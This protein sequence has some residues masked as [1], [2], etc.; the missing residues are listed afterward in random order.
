MKRLR[1]LRPGFNDTVNWTVRLGMWWFTNAREGE[2]IEIEGHDH[3][4]W[5]ER[6]KVTSLGHVPEMVLQHHHDPECRSYG[7]LLVAMVKAYPDKLFW[8]KDMSNEMVTCIS[9]RLRSE[10]P[11]EPALKGWKP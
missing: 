10:R 4:G 6:M 9:F 11:Q 1:F 5:I 3:G 7:G 8:G 2:E